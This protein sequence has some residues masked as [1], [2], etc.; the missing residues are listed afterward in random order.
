MSI[1]FN[2]IC[3][4]CKKYK[5]AGQ[6]MGGRFSF[7]HGSNDHDGVKAV[8]DF[9]FEHM[10]CGEENGMGKSVEQTIQL[11]STDCTPEEYQDVRDET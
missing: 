10:W 1:D 9:V 3:T 8:E 6:M 7:G 11:I 2:F 5:H 4:G